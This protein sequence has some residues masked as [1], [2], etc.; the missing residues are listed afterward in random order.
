[1]EELPQD[2][3]TQLEHDHRR[4]EALYSKFRSAA[5]EERR[6]VLQEMVRGL[7]VHAAVEEQVVYPAMRQ[8]LPDG[9]QKVDHAI[10]EHRRV[11]EMLADLDGANP[12]DEAVA[13][14][15]RDLMAEVKAHVAEEEED[16]L[17]ALTKGG[18]GT[19]GAD[20]DG[21]QGREGEERGSDPAS[22]A[23]ADQWCGPGGGGCRSRRGGQGSRRRPPSRAAEPRLS[24]TRRRSTVCGS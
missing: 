8:A 19:S 24:R 4:I 13:A 23:R 6:S 16:L 20:R 5:G 15:V 11:K 7:S 12:D 10:E 14:Q 22:S 3:L 17:P 2:P 21:D 18:D 1:M 9:D